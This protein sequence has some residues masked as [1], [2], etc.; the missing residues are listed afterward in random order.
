MSYNEK[1]ASSRFAD[2]VTARIQTLSPNLTPEQKTHAS[3]SIIIEE[4]RVLELMVGKRLDYPAFGLPTLVADA[5]A[6][7]HGLKVWV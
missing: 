7:Y 1:D 3:W 5:L 4:L 2:A 6:Q